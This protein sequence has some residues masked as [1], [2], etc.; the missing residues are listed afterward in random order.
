VDNVL[1]TIFYG[2]RLS[3]LVGCSA[4]FLALLLGVTLGLVAGW[5]GGLA[6]TLIMRIADVQLSF[7]AILIALLIDGVAHSVLPREVQTRITL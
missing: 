7:P 5:R 1:S 6:D 2:T 4:V 3:L